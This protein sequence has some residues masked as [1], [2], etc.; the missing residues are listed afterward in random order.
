MQAL[1]H[2]LAFS[3]PPKAPALLRAKV[4]LYKQQGK[5]Q[6]NGR[7]A[8]FIFLL[9]HGLTTNFCLNCSSVLYSLLDLI[10]IQSEFT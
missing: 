5:L 8:P 2:S 6:Q 4:S 9:Q 1:L 3:D 10:K 7:F